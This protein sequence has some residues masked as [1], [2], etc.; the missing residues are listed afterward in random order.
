MERVH[1]FS[2][3]IHRDTMGY[4]ASL[5]VEPDVPAEAIKKAFKA[6]AQ[7]LH[8]DK[9]SSPEATADFQKIAEAYR[10]L[11]NSKS[12]A[13]YDAQCLAED[14]A[15]TGW[16]IPAAPV[17]CRF[18][19]AVSTQPRYAVFF[20]VIGFVFG[21]K[22]TEHAGV[23]CPDCG[24]KRACNDSLTTWLLG[25]WAFPFGPVRSIEALWWNMKGGKQPPKEN[26]RI[27]TQHAAYFARVGKRT[28]ARQAAEQALEFAARMKMR[29]ASAV[30]R[31]D[32]ELE[33]YL[34][35]LR[36]NMPLP[37]HPRRDRWGRRGK[38]FKVQM[39]GAVLAILFAIVAL[40]AI[41]LALREGRSEASVLLETATRQPR[42]TATVTTLPEPPTGVL[43]VLKPPADGFV[44]PLEI[45]GASG[46]PSYYIDLVELPAR[47]VALTVYLR[48]GE[49]TTVEVPLG[50]YELHYAQ[51]RQWFG[52]S[53]L[54]GPDTVY[55]TLDGR[56][57]FQRNGNK[58][59]G[60]TI[61]MVERAKRSVG[62]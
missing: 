12:R 43:N 57:T 25:W 27:L 39:T 37:R 17:A 3:G 19:G 45:I 61:E 11:S 2:M 1:I 33:G 52:P 28:M 55:G 26:F 8:P 5:A 6:K 59:D 18:C 44:A 22:V 46:G 56:F 49:R 31:E 15:E 20:S 4:Y 54:F 62:Q 30:E 35:T 32:H 29:Q 13:Q 50:R 10:V 58:V 24:T 40:G 41:A 9:N 14:A 16:P 23:Y 48:S 38:A 47:S 53:K 51:G 21:S 60:Y 42:Q 36:E 34:E 7:E